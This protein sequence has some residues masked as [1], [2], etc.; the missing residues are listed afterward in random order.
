M[1]PLSAAESTAS[2]DA[3]ESLTQTTGSEA[4]FGNLGF[5]L[6][7]SYGTYL[8]TYVYSVLQYPLSLSEPPT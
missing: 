2:A 5:L 6:P 3:S 4:I 1:R 8:S 7:T